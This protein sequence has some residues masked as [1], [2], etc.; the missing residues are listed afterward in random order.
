M[1]ERVELADGTVVQDAYVVRISDIGIAV[2]VKGV[3]TFTEMAG[4]FT[5]KKKTKEMTSYQYGD[6]REWVGYTVVKVIQ[7]NE[8]NAYALLEKQ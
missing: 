4:W 6:V 5:V 2:Y 7:I 3:H 1:D 8:E